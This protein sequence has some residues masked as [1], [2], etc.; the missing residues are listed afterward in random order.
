MSKDEKYKLTL[1]HE[2]P[3]IDD[4]KGHI[5]MVAGY[6]DLNGM[7]HVFCDF[8]DYSFHTI[9]SWQASIKYYKGKSL[10]NLYDQGILISSNDYG[11]GSPGVV[12]Y[13]KK[14]YLF[15]SNH[16]I[17]GDTSVFNGY[18]KP[19]ETGYVSS[20]IHVNIYKT[21]K[22]LAID[23]T[24][25]EHF[26]V[27]NRDNGWKSMRVDDPS[28]IIIDNQLIV[29]Y[30]GFDDNRDKSHI[31]VGV[32]TF[33]NNHLIEQGIILSS[34]YGFEMPRPFIKDGKKQLFVR[35]FSHDIS[36]WSHYIF[37]NNKYIL[38]DNQF[39]YGHP[40]SK[41]MDVSF[42]CDTFGNLTG[43]VLA[44]GTNNNQLKQWAYSLSIKS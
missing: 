1:V 13:Q 39:F 3:V 12:V 42:I 4:P 34:T 27:L 9:H 26:E 22:Q 23:T 43:D 5:R 33:L 28:P 16:K 35:N 17:Y 19:G 20:D 18:S 11:V 10:T 7:Y 30:K 24:S 8:I 15:Y 2:H 6:R 25:N 14:V 32:G 21:D 44:C 41:A 29:Y 40:N 38:H 31:Q 37:R 36:S